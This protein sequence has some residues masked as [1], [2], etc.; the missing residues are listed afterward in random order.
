MEYSAIT[1]SP[2]TDESPHITTE[3]NGKDE[4]VE[5]QAKSKSSRKQNSAEN[6][7]EN[8][9]DSKTKDPI[10]KWN[11]QSDK[12]L[13]NTLY[14]LQEHGLLTL[15]AI[16]AY[17]ENSNTKKMP[18]HYTLLEQLT[19]WK[20]GIAKLTYRIKWLCDHNDFSVRETKHFKHLLSEQIEKGKVNFKDILYEFPGKTKEYIKEMSSKLC[21]KA[22]SKYFGADL[23]DEFILK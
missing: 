4:Q 18:E 21:E 20:R 13:F 15:D 11:R 23:P 9:E 17:A 6:R 2:V 1:K 8:D 22:H 12:V 14:C 7:K 5:N 3:S 19:G 16:L 10:V